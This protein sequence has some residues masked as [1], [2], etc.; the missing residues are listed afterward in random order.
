MAKVLLQ[1]EIQKN[2]KWTLT[3]KGDFMYLHAVCAADTTTDNNRQSSSIQLVKLLVEVG[4]DAALTDHRTG[5][6]AMH[7]AAKKG[8]CHLFGVL[9]EAGCPVDTT[10]DAGKTPLQI[11]LENKNHHPGGNN[12]HQEGETLLMELAKESQKK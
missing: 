6:T 2:P 10:N 7:V 12:T 8:N 11:L 3:V 9:V 1:Q 5:D 4:A